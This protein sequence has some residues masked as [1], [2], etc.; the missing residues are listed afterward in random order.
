MTFLTKHVLKASILTMALAFS[1]FAEASE[2]NKKTIITL[3][4]TVEV[5]GATLTPGEYVVRLVDSQANRNI[6]RFLSADE[7]EV[8]ST[9][10]AIPN[11]RLEPTGDTKFSF[12]E[13]PTGQP[14]ALRAWFYPGDLAGQEFAY[15]ESRA[16]RLSQAS[17]MDVPSVSDDTQTTLSEQS[18]AEAPVVLKETTVIATTRPDRSAQAEAQRETETTTNQQ[19]A[20]Q[21][22]QAERTSP[23]RAPE[24]VEEDPTTL[25]QAQPAPQ[26]QPAQQT[27]QRSQ[28]QDAQQNQQPSDQL[29]STASPAPLL[30][31]IGFGSL[32]MSLGLRRYSRR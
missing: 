28:Q 19:A 7:T 12:Y 21:T 32:A 6:V 10:I 17:N 2:M 25:A 16:K 4:E 23:A 26:R 15:P 3:N 20:R 8:L 9:V 11:R 14:P 22:E 24:S 13:M 27:P 5:P 31:L 29:P 30:A 1:P 18:D